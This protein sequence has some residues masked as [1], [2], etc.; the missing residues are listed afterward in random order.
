MSIEDVRSGFKTH[1]IPNLCV[2][3]R[4]KMLTYYH[5]C[6]AFSTGSALTFDAIWDLQSLLTNYFY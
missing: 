6:C 4:L 5:V 3:A 2:A 1:L